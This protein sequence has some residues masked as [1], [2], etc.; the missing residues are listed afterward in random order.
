[1]EKIN[2][3]LPESN[4]SSLKKKSRNQFGSNLPDNRRLNQ[5]LTKGA[6]LKKQPITA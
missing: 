5:A 2:E 1:M 6:Q 3:K 4:V